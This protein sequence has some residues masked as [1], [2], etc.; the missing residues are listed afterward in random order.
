VNI[1]YLKFVKKF[2]DKN[3]GMVIDTCMNFAAKIMAGGPG[4]EKIKM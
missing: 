3:P 1:T 4:G 2:F